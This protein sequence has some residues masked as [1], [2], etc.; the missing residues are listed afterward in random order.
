MQQD[1]N[2][3]ENIMILSGSG[4]EGNSLWKQQH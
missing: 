1:N 4:F 2:N 3:S